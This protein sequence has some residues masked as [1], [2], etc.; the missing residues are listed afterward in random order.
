MLLEIRDRFGPSLS[1]IQLLY[2]PGPILAQTV[3]RLEYVEHC[4][5]N[6][7]IHQVGPIELT[8]ADLLER[9]TCVTDFRVKFGDTRLRHELGRG[10]ERVS[11]RQAGQQQSQSVEVQELL[12]LLTAG[13]PRSPPAFPVARRQKAVH[14]IHRTCPAVFAGPRRSLVR[15]EHDPK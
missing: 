12:R 4:S 9:P 6:W 14:R 13:L 8:T 3:R 10:T 7:G 2:E 1:D 11:R 5:R 15:Q